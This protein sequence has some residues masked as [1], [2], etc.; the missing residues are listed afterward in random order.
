MLTYRPDRFSDISNT[1]E[2][3]KLWTWL[4][5]DEP[6][7]IMHT[8]CALRRPA[9]EALSPHLKTRFPVL[10]KHQ[11]TRQMIGHMVRQVLVADGFYMDRPNVRVRAPDNVFRRGSTYVM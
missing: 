6:R 11:K 2:A 8:A 9:V 7:L 4:Q 3:Q 10:C 1:P 5:R